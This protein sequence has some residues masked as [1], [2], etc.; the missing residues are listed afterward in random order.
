MTH[1]KL[2]L[3][4]LTV[5]IVAVLDQYSKH[6]ATKTF[7]S[8]VNTGISFGLF[9]AWPAFVWGAL[10]MMLLVGLWLAWRNW[11]L[12]FPV[13]SGMFFGGAVSNLFDRFFYGGVRD[14]LPIPFTPLHNNIADWAV[15][16]GLFL[17]FWSL[18]ES[19]HHKNFA[20]KIANTTESAELSAEESHEQE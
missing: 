9:A 16:A 20:K 4:S 17:I 18:V 2:L 11:W 10:L 8:N 14:W 3:S 6:Y 13:G 1:S 12:D 19:E 15:V 5:G 7:P